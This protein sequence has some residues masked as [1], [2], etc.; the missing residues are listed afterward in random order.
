ML[1]LVLLPSGIVDRV[2]GEWSAD[3]CVRRTEAAQA[4]ARLRPTKR[5]FLPSVPV[6]TLMYRRISEGCAV[7]SRRCLSFLGRSIGTFVGQ[8]LRLPQQIENHA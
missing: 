6:R 7:A 8:A 3:F 2:P 5:W 4:Q 1:L